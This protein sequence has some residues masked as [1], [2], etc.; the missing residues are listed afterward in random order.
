M[1]LILRGGAVAG[2]IVKYVA[3]CGL[4]FIQTEIA[5][6]AVFLCLRII[7]WLWQYYHCNRLDLLI[8]MS[9]G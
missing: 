3:G 7:V 1:W 6:M 4:L 2:P 5:R 8:K 9:P